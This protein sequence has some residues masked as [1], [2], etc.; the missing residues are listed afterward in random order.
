MRILLQRVSRASVTVEGEIVGSIGTGLLIL[1]GIGKGDSEADIA[2]L[3]AKSVNLRIFADETGKMN[4]SLIDVGGA[5]LVISQFTLYADSAK[6]NRPSYSEAEAPER[7]RDLFDFAVERYG[8]LL[9]KDRVA[10]GR[11]GAMMEVELVND[12]P[13]T[14]WLSSPA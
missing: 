3:V 6:G 7:A 14:L 2:A 5:A 12:G 11:F 4:L 13:V 8:E 10:T 9:G 1:V